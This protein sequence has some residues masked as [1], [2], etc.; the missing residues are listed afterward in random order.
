MDSCLF[1]SLKY[2][3]DAPPTL[4]AGYTSYVNNLAVSELDFLLRK[5]VFQRWPI[6]R[7]MERH[8]RQTDD[9]SLVGRGSHGSAHD[10][11]CV[12]TWGPN[13]V[14]IHRLQGGDLTG[15]WFRGRGCGQPASS[16]D[17]R[18]FGHRLLHYWELLRSGYDGISVQGYGGLVEANYF[19]GMS[20]GAIHLQA[21]AVV[22]A[23]NTFTNVPGPEQIDVDVLAGDGHRIGP[24]NHVTSDVRYYV[25]VHPRATGEL[26][27]TSWLVPKVNDASGGGW[28]TFLA[29]KGTWLPPRRPVEDAPTIHRGDGACFKLSVS[30]AGTLDTRL[31]RVPCPDT[32]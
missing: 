14:R 30:D 11:Q 25:N 32:R 8:R 18:R 7:Y 15:N 24:N 13:A 31:P 12:R 27:A 16:V 4:N 19:Q 5:Y 20:G 10:G 17:H 28:T 6:G 29:D 9:Q 26:F 1:S 22:V 21:G 23:A 2:G 3:I